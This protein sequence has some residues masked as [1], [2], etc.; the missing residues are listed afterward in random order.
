MRLINSNPSKA[1]PS[2]SRYQRSHAITYKLKLIEWNL[3][4]PN[5]YFEIVD[6]SLD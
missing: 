2:A 1:L 6:F 3:D 5:F 4:K